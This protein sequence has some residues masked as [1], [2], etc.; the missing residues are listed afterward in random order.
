MCFWF[1]K[2]KK[3][4]FVKG[5]E[6][7]TSL[8]KSLYYF[9]VDNKIDW[10][11]LLGASLSTLPYLGSSS[12]IF[13][14][15]K[16]MTFSFIVISTYFYLINWK[17]LKETE[18]IESELNSKLKS[19]IDPDHEVSDC[20]LRK[21]NTRIFDWAISIKAKNGESIPKIEDV[22]R[23]KDEVFYVK[24]KGKKVQLNSKGLI[25]LFVMDLMHFKKLQTFY[26][27]QLFNYCR[28]LLILFLTFLFFMIY[29]IE[30]SM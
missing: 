12:W 27:S 15:F 23:I 10:A 14:F 13:L 26:Q 22:E 20:E 4:K 11:I 25:S 29:T 7:R 8:E 30:V 28:L 2:K 9:I 6:H 18:D 24:I 17:K 5:I 21:L 19:L 16:G 3:G 1:L